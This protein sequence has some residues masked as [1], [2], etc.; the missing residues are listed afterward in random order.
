MA[1]RCADG[2]LRLNQGNRERE[3][4]WRQ[5]LASGSASGLSKATLCRQEGLAEQPFSSWKGE[6]RHRDGR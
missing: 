1:S 5:V 4:H 2:A 6:L 3:A